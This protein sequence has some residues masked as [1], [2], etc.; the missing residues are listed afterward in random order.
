MTPLLRGTPLVLNLVVALLVVSLSDPSSSVATAFLHPAVV[1]L[2][3]PAA[4]GTPSSR[5]STATKTTTTKRFMVMDFLKEGKKALV[6]KLAGDYDQTAIRTRLD[7]LI[8]DNPVLM[9]TFET[10]PYCV[11]ARQVLDA[12]NCRYTNL[13]LTSDPDG[14]AIRAELGNLVGR[15]S[16]PAIWIDGTFIGGCNDGPVGG[17]L[18]K[19]NKDG[20]LDPMLSAVGAI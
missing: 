16:V 20:K 4:V 18:A 1:V 6:R 3:S 11:K 13:D 8:R 19:L 15:T 12:K 5:S 9:L 10:C 2:S 14:K 7:G 17:G